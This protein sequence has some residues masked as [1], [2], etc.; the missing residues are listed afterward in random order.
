MV[1][2]LLLTIMIPHSVHER[3][4]KLKKAIDRYRYA[5]HVLD[6]HL[7]SPA[8]LDSLKHELTLLEEEYPSIIT[9][10]SPSQR[11][12]GKPLPAFKKVKHEV[13][14]W[15]FNDC[16][17]EEE[18]LSFEERVLRILRGSDSS[19]KR[20]TYTAELKIDGLKV[21]L[22]Y[23]KGV[24]A[25]AATRGDGIVGEDVTLN[26][27]TIESVPLRLKKDIDII[28]EGEIWMNKEGLKE[29]NR[30]RAKAGEPL[31]ANPRNAAAGSIRQLD[32]K[33]AASR[34]LDSYI[35]DVARSEAGIPDTQTEELAFL[36]D[37]GFK[38][39]AH[40]A[41]CKSISEVSAFWRE[42]KKKAD[43][44]SY[45]IDGIVIKVDEKRSQE[46]LGY[47]G[48]A[49]RFAIAYKFPAEQTTT[50]L[51]D[52]VMQV[53]RTGIITPVAVLRPVSVAG[54]TV[55]RATL[56][57]EDEIKRLDVRIGDTV[58]MQKAGDVIPDIVGVV[59]ELRPREAKSFRFPRRVAACGGDGRIERVSG[60]AAWRCVNK[61]SL[62][63][64]KRKLYHFA[65]KHAF[66]I[67]HLGPKNIDLLMEHNLIAN[68]DDIFTL[69]VGDLASLPRFAEKSAENLIKAI[70]ARRAISLPRF[71]V[72]LSIPNVGE[73]TAEDLAGYFGTLERI[74]N[75][76]EEELVGIYGIGEIV[77]RSVFAWF[78]EHENKELVKRLLRHV[79]VRKTEK[80]G[81]LP[82]AGL[83]FVFTGT[84]SIPRDDAKKKIK[85][86]GGDVNSSVSK[87]TSYCVA[88][89]N[90]GSKYDEAKKLG[91]KIIDESGF[92]NILESA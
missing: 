54:S 53:G 59:K 29:L 13:P 2:Y 39:N 73:E 3:Y 87:N 82:L 11:V 36:R 49:P 84:L 91:V 80:T 47:T 68:F 7:I 31:F 63:Q 71:L 22:T 85:A 55:S 66:D 58:I 51:E 46:I 72:S 70:D 50:V 56:H 44:Q 57:N 52:I 9:S 81:K 88:G 48:K 92:A 28:V 19:S 35:Y 30:A 69:K 26:V 15:S 61:K 67:E 24:L 45:L 65:G 21:V 20:P 60:E 16:F 14:Q 37:L 8:A 40:Y 90:P 76:S 75:A 10:D 78:R 38:V 27:K 12:A 33:V 17:N 89:E 83:S 62:A 6:R 64:L 4:E 5:E 34:K 43:K 79:H 41:H 18:L 86:L 25:V 32:P 77:G 42:W 23:E 1:Y 74:E